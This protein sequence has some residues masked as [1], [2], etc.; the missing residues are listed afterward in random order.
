MSV[1]DHGPGLIAVPCGNI[2]RYREFD[3]NLAALEKPARSHVDY[4]MGANIAASINKCILM[5]DDEDEWFW[6]MNDDHVFSKNLL[7]NLLDRD[8]DVVIPLCCS[9]AQP[10]IPVILDHFQQVNHSHQILHFRLV[11]LMLQFVQ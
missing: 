9:R 4:R 3:M 1:D 10:Y 2:G 7:V 6:L 11:E 8:V 5:M